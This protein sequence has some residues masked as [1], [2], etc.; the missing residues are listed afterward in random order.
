MYVSIYSYLNLYINNINYK[1]YQHP[2]FFIVIIINHNKLLPSNN[3]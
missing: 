1:L 2:L 3:N